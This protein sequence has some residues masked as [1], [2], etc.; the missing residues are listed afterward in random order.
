MGILIG[1]ES[2][3]AKALRGDVLNAYEVELVHP[4][5]QNFPGD[6]VRIG[7]HMVA[8][9]LDDGYTWPSAP[10]PVDEEPPQSADVETTGDLA[11]APG[12]PTT[13]EVEEAEAAL[14]APAPKP[15]KPAVKKATAVAVADVPETGMDDDRFKKLNPKVG[16]P[17]AKMAGKPSK[18]KK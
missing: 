13:S 4:H 1:R 14:D 15:K 17:P 16:K 7:G 9:A 3:E 5:Q 11:F 6:T 10:G 12:L 2:Y 8:R 18:G